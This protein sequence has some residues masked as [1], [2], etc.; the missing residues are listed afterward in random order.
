MQ[1]EE[2]DAEFLAVFMGKDKK[3]MKHDTAEKG[4]IP[5]WVDQQS[6]RQAACHHWC[7]P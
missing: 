6:R 5:L 2:G 1:R 7:V 3:K 4:G